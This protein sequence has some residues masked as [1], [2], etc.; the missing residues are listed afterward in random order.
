MTTVRSFPELFPQSWK[1]IVVCSFHLLGLRAPDLD[2]YGKVSSMKLHEDS[3]FTQVGADKLELSTQSSDFNP[4][5]N[6]WDKLERRR[7]PRPDISV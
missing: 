1:H 7:Q 6:H 4:T 5:E 2:I 3:W